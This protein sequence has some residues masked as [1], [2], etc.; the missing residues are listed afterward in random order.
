MKTLF[1]LCILACLSLAAAHAAGQTNAPFDMRGNSN[2]L[3]VSAVENVSPVIGIGR[4]CSKMPEIISDLGLPCHTEVQPFLVIA[5]INLHS[6]VPVFSARLTVLQPDAPLYT[7][8]RPP[9]A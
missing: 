3:L 8:F 2:T 7:V 4:C 9:I 6:T 5:D 1:A